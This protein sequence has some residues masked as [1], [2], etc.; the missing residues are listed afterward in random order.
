[1]QPQPDEAAGVAQ[2]QPGQQAQQE[3][4]HGDRRIRQHARPSHWPTSTATRAADSEPISGTGV[5][6]VLGRPHDD[7][8]V[9]R[10]GRHGRQA[11]AADQ[12]LRHRPADYAAE[13]QAERGRGHGQ[14]HDAGDGARLAEFLGIGRTGAV[15]A[16]QRDGAGDQAEERVQAEQL[17]HQHA[18]RVL[19]QQERHQ[20]QQEAQQPRPAAQHQPQVGGETE[21]GEEQQQQVGPR[22]VHQRDGAAGCGSSAAA[23]MANS[24]P[25]MIGAGML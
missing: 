9:L 14:R 22:R 12:P 25:P 5:T 7:A 18:E 2:H 6:G 10:A 19:R 3:V 21:A 8:A 13:H 16:D 24:T 1:M 23:A 20:R 17:G 4:R 11:E 15:P